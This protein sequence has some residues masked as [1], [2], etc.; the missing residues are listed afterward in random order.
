MHE[1]PT[2]HV[3][4]VA[5]YSI[6][7]V[8]VAFNEW[9]ESA[10]DAERHLLADAFRIANG[11]GGNIADVLVKLLSTREAAPDAGQTAAEADER[12]ESEE[13]TLHVPDLPLYE[14]AHN[15]QTARVIWQRY[16]DLVEAE[17]FP[18][19]FRSAFLRDQGE[20]PHARHINV[21]DAQLVETGV[22]PAP[23]RM[24]F[25]RTAV[26]RIIK[27]ELSSGFDEIAAHWAE[28]A[29]ATDLAAL[30]TILNSNRKPL[31]ALSRLLIFERTEDREPGRAK[32][33]GSRSGEAN[34][35]RA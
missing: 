30:H 31:E 34:S 10:P 12:E 16:P 4:A 5:T 2:D 19:P 11:N 21:W 1:I 6:R 3:K 32:E 9:A 8:T 7:D 13:D 28:R 33:T 22:L 17:E 14:F 25:N 15:L 27:A 24:R 35:A 26:Y 29:S 20:E 18:E 23:Q